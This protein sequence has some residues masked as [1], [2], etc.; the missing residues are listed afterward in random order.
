MV[1]LEIDGITNDMF[2]FRST[3]SEGTGFRIV[4]FYNVT[5]IIY[6]SIS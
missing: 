6:I 3:I 1:L 5:Y 2:F 4:Y